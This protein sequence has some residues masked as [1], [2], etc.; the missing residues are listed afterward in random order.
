VADKTVFLTGVSAQGQA[1]PVPTY[2]IPASNTPEGRKRVE[3]YHAALGRFVALFSQAEL[4]VQNSLRFYSGLSANRAHLIFSGTRADAGIDLIKSLTTEAGMEPSKH[5]ELSG[6]L[7]QLKAINTTRNAILHYG[8][9]DVAEGKP[10]VAKA[11]FGVDETKV[12]VVTFPIAPDMLEDMTA[13]VRSICLFLY[14]EHSGKPDTNAL[15]RYF[16]RPPWRY[17]PQQRNQLQSKKPEGQRQPK[18][19]AKRLRQPRS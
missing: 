18:P 8:A 4:A 14:L 19:R 5:A 9:Q 7:A 1:A 16:G 3:E 10:Y 12:K 6:A 13:D 15:M 2:T 11:L 17:K